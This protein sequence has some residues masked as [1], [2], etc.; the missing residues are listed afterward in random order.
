MRVT[1]A[2]LITSPST[3]GNS[4]LDRHTSPKPR[5]KESVRNHPVDDTDHLVSPANTRRAAGTRVVLN[6]DHKQKVSP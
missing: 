1:E 5:Q 4:S 2:L 3:P 6:I